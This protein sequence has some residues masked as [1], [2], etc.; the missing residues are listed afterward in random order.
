M[1]DNQPI[2]WQHRKL[3]H[4]HMLGRLGRGGMGEVWL[5]EDEQYHHRHVAVKLLPGVLASDQNYLRLF[6]NEAQAVAALNHP[7]I[8]QVHDFG[9]ERIEND[10]VITYLV[11]PYITGG[12]LRDRIRAA[13]GP[14]PV[15][16]GIEYLK[17]AAQAIDYAHSRQV[18]HR[19]VKP[20]NMLLKEDWL[21]LADFGVAKLLTSD[22][23]RSRTSVGAGTPEYMAPEQTQGRAEAASDLYSLVV[24]AYQLFTGHLPFSGDT[25]YAIMMKQISTAP[26]P[27]RQFY[28]QM[29]PTIESV[30]LRGLSKQPS[31]R[32]P[33]CMAF[34][35][36]LERAGRG[37][38][39]S[40]SSPTYITH[41]R[42]ATEAA[43]ASKMPALFTESASPAMAPM[44]IT[45]TMHQQPG[46]MPQ[47]QIVTEP[48][49]NSR[50][51]GIT[52]PSSGAYSP[53]EISQSS[54]PT[55]GA[56][57]DERRSKIGRRVMLAGGAVAVIAAV[58]GGVLIVVNN[59]TPAP[60][61]APK[62]TPTPVPGPKA[63]MSG[64]PVLNLTGHSGIVTNVHWSSD[65]LY[66][67]SGA[68]DTR[69][70]LWEVG[71]T[72]Q[73]PPAALQTLNQPKS[74]WKFTN[75]IEPVG[76]N[77]SADNKT[78][79]VGGLDLGKLYMIDIQNT[80][81]DPRFASDSTLDP[82]SFDTPSYY[83]PCWQPHGD[84]FAATEYKLS[85]QVKVTLWQ[86]NNP[87][88]P[89]GKLTYTDPAAASNKQPTLLVCAWSLTGA[90]M[91]GLISSNKVLIWDVKTKAIKT[92]FDLP[93]RTN[94]KDVSVPFIPPI[95]WSP[96]DPNII[97]VWDL[98]SVAI[99]DITKP[100]R[101]LHQLSTD[102]VM[103]LTPPKNLQKGEVWFPTING[104]AWSPNGRYVAASYARSTRVYVWDL[105]VPTPKK[106]KD[107]VSHIQDFFFP[108][109]GESGHG[110]TVIDVAWSPDGRYIA[111]SSFD[112]SIIVWQVD[113]DAG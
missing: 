73:K 88:T 96:F 85:S 28:P 15:V 29:S 41:D 69:V 55:Q 83:T 105:Q 110:N 94:G 92:S 24:T 64:K 113:Q 25:T 56:S 17:Q 6:E 87:A 43:G 34:I 101:P 68:E 79:L 81:D 2:N 49:L 99:Y 67:A 75:K 35:E 98:D 102:D 89:V 108:K 3:G 82:K 16:E 103:A 74:K 7:H 84:M 109:E 53:P 52:P 33:S 62:A 8:L 40:N 47:G 1:T 21:L 4:Y 70:M 12:T 80:K 54:I 30:L 97:A 27:P 38:S 100:Q 66:L 104:I 106:G 31:Q 19:D 86:K 65:N 22:T 23:Y 26:P 78:L 5:A 14:L 111:T 91:A 18:L 59:Q 57:A 37:E 112:K 39:I 9:E 20:S 45:P 71:A 107:G 42:Y 76:L 10:E 72:L 77:W 44:Q 58:A 60:P 90:L 13:N 95:A 61:P 93:D 48:G 50:P 46:I 36:A 63:I 51:T 32:Y 11:M